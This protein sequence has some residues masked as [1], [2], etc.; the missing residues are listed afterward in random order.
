MKYNSTPLPREPEQYDLYSY[1][2]G[3]YLIIH[4]QTYTP[5]FSNEGLYLAAGFQ[6]NIGIKR[7]FKYSLDKP[8]S[9]CIKDVD[10]IDCYDSYYFKAMFRELKV[11]KYRRKQCYQ[12]CQQDFILGNYS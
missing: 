4:N 1:N 2:R 7:T 12:L 10:S 5:V 6:T 9:N 11:Q 3:I 8:Y